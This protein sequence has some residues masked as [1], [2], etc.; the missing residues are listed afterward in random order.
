MRRALA[1][2]GLIGGIAPAVAADDEGFGNPVNAP[3]DTGAIVQIKP[4]FA[5]G[6]AKPVEKF[7]HIFFHVFIG[8]A[9]KNNAVFLQIGIFRQSHQKRMFGAAGFAP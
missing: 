3:V 5:V 1:V 9:D 7:P 4:D 6:I 8:D 2:L